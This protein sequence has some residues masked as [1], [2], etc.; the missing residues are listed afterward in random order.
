M[1]REVDNIG[2]E[3]GTSVLRASFVLKVRPN[4]GIST[5]FTQESEMVLDLAGTDL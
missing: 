1:G 3:A 4:K 2:S 5:R